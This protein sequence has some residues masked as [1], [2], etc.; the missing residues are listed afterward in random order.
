M[1]NEVAGWNPGQY[2]KFADQRL[3]PA[4]DLL[5]RI[6]LE[7]PNRVC[8]LGCGPGNVTPYLKAR[9]PQAT[10][11]GVD[12]SAA[13]LA[14]ARA[15]DASVAWVEADIANWTADQPFDLVYSN[16]ALQ[17]LGGHQTLFPH[18]LRQLAPGGRLAVQMPR[19]FAAASHA[20]MRDAALDGPWA[21]SLRPLLRHDPVAAPEVYWDILTRAGASVDLWEVEYLQVLQG[22]DAV[23]Q[24]TL[25]TALKPLL[26]ALEEPWRGQFLENYRRRMAEAYPRRA[27]GE[28]LFPFRR[29]FMLASL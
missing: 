10:F 17:W 19:N 7:A 14:K 22:E 28:T 12:S 11:T 3:R 21:E 20:G 1:T 23:V 27:S 16:A 8:D 9:W 25:G 13:M 18:L 2:L 24:W 26:D 6:D 4:L 5:S 29:L 15:A